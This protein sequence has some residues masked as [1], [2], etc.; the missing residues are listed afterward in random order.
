MDDQALLNTLG[1]V[2]SGYDIETE[3]TDLPVVRTDPSHLLEV[4][5]TARDDERLNMDC[6]HLLTVIDREVAFETVYHLYSYA[7]DH[8]F[9]VKTAIDHD[10]PRVPSVFGIWKGADY[11]ER[12]GYDLFGVIFDGHP[13]LKR[14]LL[15]ED[16]QGH[17][18][19]KDF[20][21]EWPVKD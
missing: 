11:M 6:L 7:H 9:V 21:L 10:N 17:P 18:M 12:E 3:G 20:K 15:P 14:L 13:N 19:R 1:Q 2:F 16:H 8:M 5:R 4:C